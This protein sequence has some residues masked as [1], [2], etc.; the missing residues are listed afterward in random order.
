MQKVPD[1]ASKGR[2][3]LLLPINVGNTVLDEWMVVLR[4]PKL[5]CNSE[6]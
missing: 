2:E 1:I 4:K 5:H 3:D 6:A